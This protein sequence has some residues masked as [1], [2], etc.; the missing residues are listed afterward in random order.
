MS[1]RP[2]RVLVVA[3]DR[4]F[5]RHLSQFLHVFGYEVQQAVDVSQA[6]AALESCE[7][8]FFLVDADLPGQGSQKICRWARMRDNSNSLHILLL[9][10]GPQTR[11]MAEAL[12]SGVDDFLFKPI[13]HGEVLVRLRSGAR[14]LEHERRVYQQSTIET[15]TGLLSRAMMLERLRQ[16]LHDKSTHHH[17]HACVVLDLDYFHRINKTHGHSAGRLVLKQVACALESLCP[18]AE[19]FHCWDG[20]RFGVVLPRMA[21]EKA[22]GWAEKTRTTL[23]NT[24]MKIFETVVRMT[25][26]CGAAIGPIESLDS[27]DVEKLLNEAEQALKVAKQSGRDCTVVFGQ[28][29]AEAKEWE[30]LAVPGKLFSRT[31]ARD[32]MQ[33]VPGTLSEEECVERA[34]VQLV[35]TGME[36]I[37]VVNQQG[38]LVGVVREESLQQGKGSVGDVM[39][40]DVSTCDENTTFSQLIDLCARQEVDQIV[41]TCREQPTGLVT[42]GQL[43][44]LSKPLTNHSFLSQDPYSSRSEYLL[45]PDLDLDSVG[46]L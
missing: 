9:V 3:E 28:F 42:P 34:A 8:D 36:V 13:V 12:E 10:E 4:R 46:T 25:A 32:V 37:P 17:P 1:S 7:P 39:S 31:V 19:K 30:G 33:P 14:V 43:S 11:E 18:P 29:D 20:D 5:L 22:V 38:K 44:V 15:T 27:R 23:A 41:I 2:L 16:E 24:E 21:A 45:V 6:R 26:S 35:L 40:T